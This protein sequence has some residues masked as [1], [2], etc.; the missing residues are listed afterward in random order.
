[1]FQ[2][3]YFQDNESVDGI[4]LIN[5]A[6]GATVLQLFCNTIKT[7]LDNVDWIISRLKAEYAVM[8]YPGEENPERSKFF[9]RTG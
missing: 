6:S 7:M 5:D 4:K 2:E 8:I 9:F 3:S 1:M